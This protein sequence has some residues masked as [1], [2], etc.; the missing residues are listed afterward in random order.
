VR[1]SISRTVRLLGPVGAA[2]ALLLACTAQ[3]AKKEE[4][5]CTPD[6][7]V[8]CRCAD[9]QEGQK[10]CKADGQ[11]FGPCEPCET[12]DNPEVPIE[13]G[14]PGPDEPFEPFEP[15]PRPEAGADAPPATRC[16]DGIVQDGEDCD[17]DDEND[18]DGCDRRCKLAG[19]QPPPSNACPGLDV[20]VWG[21]A[22]KPTLSGT[23]VGS[24]NRSANPKCSDVAETTGSTAPDRVFKVFAHKT[25]TLT[26]ALTD[27]SYNAFLYVS[28]A[29]GASQNTYL[30]C[31]NK[32]AGVGDESI[33]VPVTAGKSYWVFVDGSGLDATRE[34]DFRVTFSIR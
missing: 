26:V 2:V 16:G 11:N 5:F 32:T 20:H 7:Y 24:G 6:K 4:K 8:F 17:D 25:G 19:T 34:G 31:A 13:P 28:D 22:H 3:P 27:T 21:G 10:L 1:R 14:D 30:A 18:T 12:F 15:V 33:A 23:T 9:R 29:C